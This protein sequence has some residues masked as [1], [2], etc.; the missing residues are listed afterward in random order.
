MNI[1][2]PYR[3]LRAHLNTLPVGFP[4]T[5]SGVEYKLLKKIFTPEDALRALGMDYTFRTADDISK[6]LTAKK[7]PHSMDDLPKELEQMTSRGSA[8]RRATNE[9]YA[10]LPFIVGL[11]EMQLHYAT[12]DFMNDTRRFAKEGFFLDYLST[13]IPQTRIVPIHSAVDTRQ[14]IASFDD[15]INIITHAGNS[16][17]VV[18]CICRK[19]SDLAEKSCKRT[20]RR[21]LCLTFRDFAD[22]VIREKWGRKLSRDEAIELLNENVKDGLVLQLSNEK[23][24]QFMCA[25]CK[26]CCG[27]LGMIGYFPR[28]ADFVLTNFSAEVDHTKCNGCSIC[29]KRCHTR[30]VTIDEKKA[31]IAGKRCIGCGA[32]VSACPQKAISLVSHKQT[33]TPPE[34]TEDLYRI[35]EKGKPN[36]AKRLLVGLKAIAGLKVKK[37][38]IE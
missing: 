27:L 1:K 8:L 25:C 33:L 32:C 29:K 7:I 15:V 14:R 37:H 13:A 22:T 23:N 38:F 11:F 10:I 2:K 17:A 21:E 24:P 20:T 36:T 12:K 28:P 3:T 4:R 6:R 16:I 5:L 30:A 18:E 19:S 26:C 31:R 9:T 34:N 35:I